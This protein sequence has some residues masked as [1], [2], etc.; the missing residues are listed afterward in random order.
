M[1][2]MMVE[3]GAS[4]GLRSRFSLGPP[5]TMCS[6]R[7]HHI[8]YQFDFMYARR[9]VSQSQ[10]SARASNV[11]RGDSSQSAVER[12][13]YFVERTGKQGGRDREKR[14]KGTLVRSRQ[15]VR[16]LLFA[17]GLLQ[18]PCFA[19]GRMRSVWW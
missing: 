11:C 7:V 12:E 15:A 9:S 6:K 13:G 18:L 4:V 8:V 3:I 10:L 19:V 5:T 1:R 2:W 17:S 16:V 14:R